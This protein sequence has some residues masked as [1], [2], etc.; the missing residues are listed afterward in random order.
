MEETN[1]INRAPLY[2]RIKDDIAHQIATAQ[3]APG[4]ILPTRPELAERY[5]TTTATV[6]RAMLELAREG[7]VTAGS[8][9]RT[10]V[11]AGTV[12]RAQRIAVVWS[13]PEE[14]ISG[15]GGDFFGPLIAGIQQA[16]ADFKLEVHFRSAEL[17]S[18]R[19]V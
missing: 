16:C 5:G 10:F 12:Q 13:A 4:A 19:E 3:L 18:W 8:G 6:D 9:R 1:Q 2:R 11:S 15:I 14:H 17:S 7:A